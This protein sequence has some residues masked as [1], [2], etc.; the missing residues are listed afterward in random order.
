MLKRLILAATAA[1]ALAGC[2]ITPPAE[3]AKSFV[4]EVA[5]WDGQAVGARKS[6]LE[7]TCEKGYD[8]KGLCLEAGRPLSPA[9]AL[10]MLEALKNVRG[11]LR[12]AVTIPDQGGVCLGETRTPAECLGA[13]TQMLLE[14]ELQLR[15]AQ[16]G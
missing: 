8:A 2:G 12:A 10:P 5:Y 6:V 16:G 9:A 15:R 7:L 13:A 4:E 11:G 3:Q 1:L 14:V